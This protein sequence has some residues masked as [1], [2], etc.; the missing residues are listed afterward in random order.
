RQA[1][2]LAPANVEVLAAL[3]KAQAA[4]AQA[5][6]RRQREAEAASAARAA[7][8]ADAAARANAARVAAE[9]KRQAELAREAERRKAEDEAR[10]KRSAYDTSLAQGRAALAAKNYGAAAGAFRAALQAQP[11]DPVAGRLL[12]DAERA[13]AAEAQKAAEAQRVA[14]AYAKALADGQ[15]AVQARR[16]E[17]AV[18][19]FTEARRLRPGDPAAS[20][21]LQAAQQAL[22]RAR[23]DQ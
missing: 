12:Q 18:K 10:R 6:A 21:Q 14:A 20:A 11:N 9:Q 22:V 16:H 19:A 5:A 15:V 8:A 3:N 7:A 4:Q 23:Q 13:A 17:D 1:A 2:R